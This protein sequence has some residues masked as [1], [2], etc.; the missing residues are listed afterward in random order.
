MQSDI[1]SLCHT[2]L[3]SAHQQ[4]VT[5]KLEYKGIFPGFYWIC[6]GFRRS[7]ANTRL[8][9]LL[10]GHALRNDYLKMNS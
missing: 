8:L 1:R 5:S 3:L 6:V 7:S 9:K 4:L 10:V 2:L